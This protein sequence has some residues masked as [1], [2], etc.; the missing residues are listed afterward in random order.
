MQAGISQALSTLKP[1]RCR[2]IGVRIDGV[3]RTKVLT[4]TTF[5]LKLR[6]ITI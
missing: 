4:K 1:K 5:L 2:R 3:K 6:I